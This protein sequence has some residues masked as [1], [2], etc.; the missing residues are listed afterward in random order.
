M[1]TLWLTAC[2]WD[3]APTEDVAC[4][5]DR[6][7]QRTV[8]KLRACTLAALPDTVAHPPSLQQV[9]KLHNFAAQPLTHSLIALH[10]VAPLLATRLHLQQGQLSQHLLRTKLSAI[11][12]IC[13]WQCFC[14]LAS[15]EGWL[16]HATAHTHTADINEPLQTLAW[17]LVE[18]DLQST[19]IDLPQ[20]AE[21]RIEYPIQLRPRSSVIRIEGHDVLKSSSRTLRRKCVQVPSN[22]QHLSRRVGVFQFA[23]GMRLAQRSRSGQQ[24]LHCC[25]WQRGCT[26]S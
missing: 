26:T 13:N 3:S 7:H 25:F 6:L 10:S 5:T 19:A 16:S 11:G 21:S 23:V 9:S 15:F 12:R 17:G 18:R 2:R 4:T 24:A 22:L 20:L 1:D 8:I 14:L